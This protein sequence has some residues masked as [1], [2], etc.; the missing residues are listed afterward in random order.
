MTPKTRLLGTFLLLL[1]ALAHPAQAGARPESGHGELYSSHDGFR[2]SADYTVVFDPVRNMNRIDFT[3]TAA[4][5]QFSSTRMICEMF[6]YAHPD[7]PYVEYV[8]NEIDST[9]PGPANAV[10]DAFNV[11]ADRFPAERV[12]VC[13]SLPDFA[14]YASVCTTRNP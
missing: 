4:Q 12:K 14:S 9:K 6:A 11:N 10:Q 7:D 5:V 13:V 8:S 3:C 1:A 2:I